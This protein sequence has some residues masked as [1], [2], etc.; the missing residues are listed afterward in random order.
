M[1]GRSVIHGNDNPLKAPEEQNITLVRKEGTEY[2][3]TGGWFLIF[4]VTIYLDGTGI[5]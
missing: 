2:L 5:E 1:P 4:A 3:Q